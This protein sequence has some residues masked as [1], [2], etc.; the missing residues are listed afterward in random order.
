KPRPPAERD[1]ASD[2]IARA[3]KV[4][5]DGAPR[6]LRWAQVREMHGDGIEFGAHTV[7]HPI[8]SSLRPEAAFNEIAHSKRVIEETLQAPV[9]HFAYPNGTAEDFDRGTEELVA[10]A[11]FTS[12]VST[13]FGVNT[14]TTNRYALRRGGPW[15]EDPAVFGVKLWWYRWR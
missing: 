1:V 7:N 4:V 13:I 5:L 9:R 6:M 15:E 2:E 8:L 3:L 10:R 11:G 12:A 14:S